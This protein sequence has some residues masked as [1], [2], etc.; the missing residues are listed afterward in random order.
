[1]TPDFSFTA[2]EASEAIRAL[3]RGEYD[4]P[5]L[6]RVGPLFESR[7]D[8]V[9]LILS[10]VGKEEQASVVIQSTP[11]IVTQSVPASEPKTHYRNGREVTA[12]RSVIIDH[13]VHTAP[14]LIHKRWGESE[15]TACERYKV[16]DCTTSDDIKDV[17]CT[18][19][20]KEYGA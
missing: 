19:C 14:P 6:E 1:M 2:K 17:T 5:L 13:H 7:T 8:N 12:A 18:R 4:H 9:R 10:G 16:E 3:M 11:R 15:W 20:R